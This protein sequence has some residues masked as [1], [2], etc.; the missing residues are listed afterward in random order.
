[1]SDHVEDEG[2][3][4]ALPMVVVVL[5]VVA[6]IHLVEQRYFPAASSQPAAEVTE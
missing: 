4:I 6:I 5:V 2:G 3:S 1:M